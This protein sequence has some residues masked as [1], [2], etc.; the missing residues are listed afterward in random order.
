M[1]M[2]Q[3][4][5]AP[6][7]RLL[8]LGVVLDTRNPVERLRE[9]ARMCD[10][11]GIGALW[12]EDPLQAPD[13]PARLEAWTALALVAPELGRARLGA[14]LDAGWRDPALLARMAATLGATLGGRLELTLRAGGEGVGDLVAAVEAL[15]RELAATRVPSTVSPGSGG[16]VLEAVALPA[17]RPT[18]G[19]AIPPA[20]AGDLGWAV[21]IADDLVLPPAPLAATVAAATAARQAAAQAGRDPVQLGIAARLPV[22]VGRTGAEAQARWDAEPA[23]AGLGRSDEVGIFGTLEQCH[24]RVAALAH[25]G[26][27]DL[28]C[29]LPNAIDIHDVIAQL[30]AMTIGSV[31]K[32]V[33]GAPRTRVPE[34]PPGWGG[35]SR[36]PQP[37]SSPPPPAAS[38]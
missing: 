27:T 4:T 18:I 23:F 26:V 11:A 6:L 28:R 12:V 9:V 15:R 8:R 31:D 21:R 32:L 13:D 3:P 16:P 38:R 2:P 17:R 5:T 34:P 22:S 37:P 10:R 14:L 33:P 29:L 24:D 25:A 35:R 1:D 7:G 19:V 36:F 20:A 30:T